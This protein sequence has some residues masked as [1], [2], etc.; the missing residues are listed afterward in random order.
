MKS[1]KFLLGSLL[2]ILVLVGC[3]REN[4]QPLL[5]SVLSQVQLFD[6][7]GISKLVGTILFKTNMNGTGIEIDTNLDGLTPGKYQCHI[8]DSSSCTTI[9]SELSSNST[10]TMANEFKMELPIITVEQNGQSKE[11]L[12]APDVHLS[13]LKGNSVVLTSIEDTTDNLSLLDKKDEPIMCGAI[14]N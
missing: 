5:E 11:V 7:S 8:Y 12:F 3:V 13:Q 9:V 14:P 1:K 10:K 6:K 2:S 4:I